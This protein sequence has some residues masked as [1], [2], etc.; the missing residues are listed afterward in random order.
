[1]DSHSYPPP[2]PQYPSYPSLPVEVSN[3]GLLPPNQL[4]SQ[5]PFPA[6]VIS[7]GQAVF[8]SMPSSSQQIWTTEPQIST[9]PYCSATVMTTVR[10]EPGAVTWLSCMGICL[11]GGGAGCCLIPFCV[12]PL[13]DCIHMCGACGRPVGKKS[14]I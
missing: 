8:Q 9:C 1:M 2:P 5:S 4:P 12:K 6:Q 13:Q 7:P 14:L 3:A 10:Y 11:L